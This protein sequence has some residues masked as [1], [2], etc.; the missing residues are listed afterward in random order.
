MHPKHDNYPEF[1]EQFWEWFDNLPARKKKMFWR[2][3]DD[4]AE[5]NF[6][7]TVWRYEEGDDE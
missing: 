6:Y 5:E 1:K 3:R 2:F 7:F 4:M